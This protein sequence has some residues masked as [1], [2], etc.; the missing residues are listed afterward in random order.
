MALNPHLSTAAA[1]AAADVVCSLVNNGWLRIY[2]GA[3]PANS[4]GAI[5]TQLLLAEC[6]FASTAFASAVVGVATA[7]A[8]AADV[9]INAT[10]T[11][12]WF[13]AFKSDGTTAVFDGSVGASGCDL[14]LNTPNLSIHGNLGIAS[15]TYTQPR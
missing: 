14:N 6:R 2:D 13:R 9:D 1:N 11:A 3:Q 8:I 10:S 4:D 5:S 7:N 15:F 12:T